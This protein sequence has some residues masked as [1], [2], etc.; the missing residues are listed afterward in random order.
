MVTYTDGLLPDDFHL[1][2]ANSIEKYIIRVEY[3]KD[4]ENNQLVREENASTL[5]V[6]F[7]AFYVQADGDAIAVPNR[8]YNVNYGGMIDG[9][10]PPSGVTTYTSYRDAITAFGAP[11]FLKHILDN[12]VVDRTYLGVETNNHLYYLSSRDSVTKNKTILNSIFGAANCLEENHDSDNPP[13]TEYRCADCLSK[14][15]VSFAYSDSIA[16]LSFGQYDI[17]DNIR[18][19]CYVSKYN[20]GIEFRCGQEQLTQEE[21]GLIGQWC[22]SS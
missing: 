19:Y 2:E 13:Y 5:N 14:I 3:K 20:G 6:T 17:E 16:L 22:P 8:V 12:G 15:D 1:L 4:I 11:I 18:K 7:D 10:T 9:Q 21:L